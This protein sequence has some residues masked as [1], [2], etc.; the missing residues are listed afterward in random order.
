[1]LLYSLFYLNSGLYVNSGLYPKCSQC[2]WFIKPNNICNY[3]KC[4]AFVEKLYLPYANVKEIIIYNYAEH[5]RKNENMC[6][7]KG[8][9]FEEYKIESKK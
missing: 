8:Y 3:G 7:A 4:K 5:C 9:L 6:G 2:K 1:M